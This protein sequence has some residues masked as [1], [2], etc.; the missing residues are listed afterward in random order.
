MKSGL[1]QM[2]K[3]KCNSPLFIPD[4]GSQGVGECKGGRNFGI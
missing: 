3:R 2:R 1:L 4:A